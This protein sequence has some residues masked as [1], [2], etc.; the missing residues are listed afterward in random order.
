M[1]IINKLIDERVKDIKVTRTEFTAL[2]KIVNDLAK[3]QKR[4]EQRVEELAQAQKRTEQRVEELAQA[5]KRTEQR[6]EELAQ[7]QKKTEERLDA[8]TKR[9]DELAQAQ[10]RTEERLDAL[11]Q[12]VDELAQA[13]KK[14]E[15]TLQYLMR[16][17][18]GLSDRIGF[19]LEDL[20]RELLPSY[21]ELN[22][23]IK[24]EK[25]EPYWFEINGKKVE[26]NFFGKGIKSGKEIAILGESQ[27]RISKS[28][29][30]ELYEKF[31]IIEPTIKKE[32]FK[33]IFGFSIHPTGQE[34]AKEKKIELIATYYLKR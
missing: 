32:C 8:L 30:D 6:V 4:T 25:L 18:K 5:Q 1:R 29:V 9:V 33:F 26:L 15:E 19:S 3:A 13:Q 31:S 17:V 12:R 14:T 20:G 11:T 34:S 28:T 2:R 10:K 22:F 16:E 27:S 24:I 7:A 23:G 21:L